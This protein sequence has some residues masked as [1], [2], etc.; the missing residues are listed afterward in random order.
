[1]ICFDLMVPTLRSRKKSTFNTLIRVSSLFADVDP[2]QY[3]L[4]LQFAFEE[5]S[6]EG[7]QYICCLNAGTLSQDHLGDIALNEVVRF[8]LTDDSGK[9]R[10]LGKRLSAREKS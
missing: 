9:M 10:L 4:A 2:R 8:K 7:F 5:A 1:M 3:G 6:G